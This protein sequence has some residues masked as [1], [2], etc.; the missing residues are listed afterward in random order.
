M[1]EFINPAENFFKKM[2]KIE[3][4]QNYS[5]GLVFII[6]GKTW[7]VF[8][9]LINLTHKNKQNCIMQQVLHVLYVSGFIYHKKTEKSQP[10]SAPY[11]HN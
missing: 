6:C 9:F 5:L 11:S 2:T 8:A 3:K 7:T 10:H 4:I 1:S